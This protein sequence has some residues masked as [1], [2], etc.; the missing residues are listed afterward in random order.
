MEE[1][2]EKEW[3]RSL[4][5]LAV[6][7]LRGECERRGKQI[8]FRLFETSDLDDSGDGRAS[9]EQLARDFGIAVTDVTNHLSYT[10][11]EFRR[12]ALEKLRE[13][14]ASDEEFRREARAIFGIDPA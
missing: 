4:F 2:F 12:I 5:S 8:H 3:V 1:F 11:R 6:E 10:R 9:Y 7:T 14:C 13:M